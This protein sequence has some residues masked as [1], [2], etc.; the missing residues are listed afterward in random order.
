MSGVDAC[1]IRLQR[2]RV[3]KAQR[4]IVDQLITKSRYPVM[5]RNERR[6]FEYYT[7]EI[8]QLKAQAKDLKKARF[9]ARRIGLVIARIRKELEAIKQH[10]SDYRFVST[11]GQDT[12]TGERGAEYEAYVSACSDS[13]LTMDGS[14][15]HAWIE[16]AKNMVTCLRNFSLAQRLGNYALLWNAQDDTVTS[17]LSGANMAPCN[18]DNTS[19]T[20]AHLQYRP[21]FLYTQYST[22]C[23]TVAAVAED[24]QDTSAT[25]G[26]ALDQN[27]SKKYHNYFSISN[28][29]LAIDDLFKQLVCQGDVAGGGAT[30]SPF[31]P[32]T[33]QPNSSV[34]TGSEY[35]S[36]ST[37]AASG[38]TS[39][40]GY[41]V[42]DKALNPNFTDV[43]DNINGAKTI[44]FD[45][46][47]GNDGATVTI[48]DY[49][50]YGNANNPYWCNISWDPTSGYGGI[51]FV[52]RY[53]VDSTTTPYTF[54]N[55]TFDNETPTETT[56]N[57]EVPDSQ[58]KSAVN[59]DNIDDERDVS[60]VLKLVIDKLDAV[61]HA[62][63][64]NDNEQAALECA[65]DVNQQ[66]LCWFEEVCAE[67]L[68]IDEDE[69]KSQ[70]ASGE[71]NLSDLTDLAR[72]ASSKKDYFSGV[73]LT[74]KG[75]SWL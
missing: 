20:T 5:D 31:T 24:E 55:F 68:A 19:A 12:T 58:E 40:D 53:F 14:T 18:G 1:F 44:T 47:H 66:N 42:I 38:Y 13:D 30:S 57:E 23:R 59:L 26:M 17:V 61:M 11:D 28:P 27:T 69:L 37:S 15:R 73:Q 3:R 64:D 7:D 4:K 71:A 62:Q 51:D 10:L 65:N 2:D 32:T 21:E 6:T 54:H 52:L 33:F 29:D 63:Q 16:Q 70:H 75:S 36:N 49:T 45:G 9:V 48:L 50:D 74:S 67:M 39:T 41:L 46:P 25:S 60:C 22:Q 34:W 8:A 35:N 43:F 72:K 56:A